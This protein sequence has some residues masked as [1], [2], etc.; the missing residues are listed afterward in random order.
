VACTAS[1]QVAAID[2]KNKLLLALLRVGGTPVSLM[3]KP[4][5]GE[6][7]VCNFERIRSRPSTHVERG[8]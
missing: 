7:F 4:D 6:L 3:L 8:Q 5:G 1:H 2:L